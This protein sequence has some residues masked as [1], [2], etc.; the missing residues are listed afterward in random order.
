MEG[1]TA[2]LTFAEGKTEY[3]SSWDG[4]E[5]ERASWQHVIA[6]PL[7]SEQL[8]W[9]LNGGASRPGTWDEPG[10][11]RPKIGLT[12]IVHLLP[13]ARA[14]RQPASEFAVNKSYRGAARIRNKESKLDRVSSGP[15][16][17]SVE[18]ATRTCLDNGGNGCVVE[19]AR[20][21]SKQMNDRHRA[22]NQDCD[23]EQ[24]AGST[25][26]RVDACKLLIY[27]NSSWLPIRTGLRRGSRRMLIRAPTYGN[28]C[29]KETGWVTALVDLLREGASIIFAPGPRLRSGVRGIFDPL[30]LWTINLLR[31]RYLTIQTAP[32]HG[33]RS[34]AQSLLVLTMCV[35]LLSMRKWSHRAGPSNAVRVSFCGMSVDASLPGVWTRQQPGRPTPG[36]LLAAFAGR[37]DYNNQWLF[38]CPEGFS[39]SSAALTILAD[40]YSLSRV[41]NDVH[42]SRPLIAPPHFQGYMGPHGNLIRATFA[43][44]HGLLAVNRHYVGVCAPPW[45]SAFTP[46]MWDRLGFHVRGISAVRG[47]KHKLGGLTEVGFQI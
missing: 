26:V 13:C 25:N 37:V 35:V 12:R 9:S 2:S 41:R 11:T 47:W 38:T 24:L 28:D 14:P 8:A 17:S 16:E 42:R 46:T 1:Q 43:S 21:K 5:R 33:L 31:G 27:A 30:A 34:P 29:H 36:G 3:V 10:E 7:M 32:I 20:A 45:N 6:G 22:A 4:P 23:S 15:S 18:Q 44:E 39:F 19:V 40:G